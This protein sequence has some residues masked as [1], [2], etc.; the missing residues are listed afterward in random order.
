MA[1]VQICDFGEKDGVKMY[2]IHGDKVDLEKILETC[3]EEDAKFEDEPV[4]EY[5]RKGIWTILLRIKIPS[6]SRW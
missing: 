4:L 5:T 6:R 1:I 2:R 3:R